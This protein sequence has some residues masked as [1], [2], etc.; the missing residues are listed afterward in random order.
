MQAQ[1]RINNEEANSGRED[2]KRK[3]NGQTSVLIKHIGQG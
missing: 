3:K 1:G 2:V